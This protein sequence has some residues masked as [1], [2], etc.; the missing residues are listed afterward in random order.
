MNFTR[1]A[2]LCACAC[3]MLAIDPVVG[4]DEADGQAAAAPPPESGGRPGQDLGVTWKV[5][6]GDLYQFQSEIDGGGSFSVNRTFLGAGLDYRFT[7]ALSMGFKIATEVD[8]Y[9]F[10]GEGSFASA[11]GGT[12]WTTTQEL[13]IGVS[14]RWDI[15]REWS[16]FGSG[17]ARWAGEPD[18]DWGDSFST[19]GVIAG[20]YAFSRDLTLGAGVLASGR[21]DGSVL[22]IPS[23]LVDW[24]ITDKLVVTNVRG[25][26]TYPAS[27]GVEILYNF[28]KDLSFSIGFRYVYR[29]FRLDDSG[30][31]A[32]RGGVGTERSF[33]MWLRL[34]WRP[35]RGTR[36]HLLGGVSFGERLEL[37]NADGIVI[38]DQDAQPAPFVALF[39]GL[40]F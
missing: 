4:Q 3:M 39:F 22:F 18:A 2:C 17:T 11:A 27:A 20:S 14:A 12:P 32:I 16:V 37:Q 13:S 35:T 9:R 36:L 24:R 8:R 25:P 10:S 15:D 5:F 38:E 34:E 29:R 7:P 31:A 26:A 1:L 19:G 40:E 33:P 21:L 30:P 23:L 6:G 28:E